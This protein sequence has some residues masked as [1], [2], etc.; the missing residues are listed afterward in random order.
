MNTLID[1]ILSRA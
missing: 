1:W